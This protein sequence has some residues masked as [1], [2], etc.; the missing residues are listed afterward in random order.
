M[1]LGS[2]TKACKLTNDVVRARFPIHCGLLEMILYE[3]ERIFINQPYLTCMYQALFA[4]G[5]YGLLRVSELA[6]N[7][8]GHTIQAKNVHVADNKEN[9]LLVLYS[10]KTHTK[11]I[12]KIKITSNKSERSGKYR[13]RNFCPFHLMKCFLSVC[14]GYDSDTEPLFILRDRNPV[15]AN[16]VSNVLKKALSR[17]NLDSSLYS[18]H[19]LRIGRVTDL[20]K[21]GYSVEE[22]KR[23][24][25]WKSNAVYKYIRS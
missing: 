1:I 24:G 23:I 11:G 8:T 25:R 12:Q 14:Q 19:S 20:I 5:Y 16:N 3:I 18:V 13:K 10:S 22:V 6:V 15:K 7:D 21:Y 9:I 2:L 17:M 4:I